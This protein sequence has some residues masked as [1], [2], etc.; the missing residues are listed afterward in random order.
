[1][2][3]TGPRRTCWDLLLPGAVA[4]QPAGPGGAE[5][6]EQRVAERPGNDPNRMV[7]LNGL[8]DKLAAEEPFVHV[9][10]YARFFLTWPNGPYDPTLREDG[11][12]VDFAG[13]AIVANWLGPELLA[14]TTRPSSPP[15]D[16]PLTGAAGPF[17][18]GGR[19][20]PAG[21]GPG[22]ILHRSFMF[23]SPRGEIRSCALPRLRVLLISPVAS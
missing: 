7:L 9:V 13:K 8:V 10:D 15:L 21:R 11:M 16:R 17:R 1:M 20:V 18:R 3:S 4:H 2:G 6:A 22:P 23:R 5:P 14:A 19:P 12:H